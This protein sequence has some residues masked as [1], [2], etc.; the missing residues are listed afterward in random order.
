LRSERGAILTTKNAG[1]IP[2][3][4]SSAGLLVCL[5][6]TLGTAYS[7]GPGRQ[8]TRHQEGAI[9]D[10]DGQ[11]RRAKTFIGEFTEKRLDRFD[12]KGQWQGEAG[13]RPWRSLEM[14]YNPATEG[15][16]CRTINGK[17]P[18]APQLEAT[19]LPLDRV[20]LL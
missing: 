19:D 18:S 13:E 4:A 15:I 20:P 11:W 10:P 1:R 3:L 7:A 17:V 9:H 12:E 14:E 2:W 16:R 8:G 6:G 5:L